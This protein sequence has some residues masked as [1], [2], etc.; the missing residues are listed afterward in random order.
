MIKKRNT[1]IVLLFFAGF[2]EALPLGFL[3]IMP[4]DQSF[5]FEGAARIAGGEVLFKDFYI[6]HGLVPC[7]LQSLFFKLFGV[8]WWNYVLH[9]A[10]FNGL[11]ILLVYSLLMHYHPEH[12]KINIWISIFSGWFFYPMVGTPYPENHSIFFGLLAV[13][14]LAKSTRGKAFWPYLIIPSLIMSYF[15]KPIPAL[16]FVLPLAVIFYF[17]GRDIIVHWTKLTISFCLTI[18]GLIAF[19]LSVNPDKFF[20]YYLYLPFSTG[21]NRIGQGRFFLSMIKNAYFFPL[22]VIF[23]MILCFYHLVL[24]RK[25]VFGHPFRNNKNQVLFLA[26]SLVLVGSIFGALTNNQLENSFS[27]CFVSFGLLFVEFAKLYQ[28]NFKLSRRNIILVSVISMIMLFDIIRFTKFNVS[29][30][31]NDMVFSYSSLHHYSKDLGLFF[32]TPEK[33]KIKLSD[34]EQIIGFLKKEKQPFCYFGD[35]TLIHSI[36]HEKSP[37]PIILFHQGLTIPPKGSKEFDALKEKLNS[38]LRRYATKYLVVENE[39]SWMKVSLYD[40]FDKDEISK[41]QKLYFG[42]FVVVKLS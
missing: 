15:S 18:L 28:L 30:K 7:Y 11:F 32:Q 25:A 42:N 4:L 35:L 10:I 40:F 27:I 22:S 26:I 23:I 16:L 1:R 17:Q 6:S 36:L 20:Y 24:N 21:T 9:G 2:L 37:F 12:R 41:K 14:F 34:L 38:N 19:L 13:V 31:Y 33:N 8:H 29:R 5:V 3:G 39:K